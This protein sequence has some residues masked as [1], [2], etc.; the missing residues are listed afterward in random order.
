VQKSQILQIVLRNLARFGHRSRIG[1]FCCNIEKIESNGNFE[2][3]LI[4]KSKKNIIKYTGFLTIVRQILVD[5]RARFGGWADV[6]MEIDGWMDE[7]IGVKPGL[8]DCS[9]QSKN[10]MPNA[11]VSLSLNE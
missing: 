8:W 11:Y 2:K 6:W 4:K 3:L 10:A 5:H 1:V 9:A 7:W